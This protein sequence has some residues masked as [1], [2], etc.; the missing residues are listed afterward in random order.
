MFP[1]NGRER[2]LRCFQRLSWRQK[3]TEN[4]EEPKYGDPAASFARVFALDPQAV[5]ARHNLA[6][7]LEKLGR[8]DEAVTQLKRALA[9]KPEYGTG[10]LALGQLY[11][12]MGRTNDADQCYNT[13]LTNR[14]NQADD[15]AALARFCFSRRQFGL[16]V[17]NFAAAVELSPSDPGLRLEAGRALVALGRHD[18]AARQYLRAVELAPDQAQPHMQLGVEQGRLGQPALAEQEF[19]QALRLD[20]NF[21]EARVDLGIALYE[22]EKLDDALK[23]FEDVLQHNPTNATAQ[24]YARLLRNRTTLPAAR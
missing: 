21:I 13:A 20:P 14:V 1:S 10:W 5:W 9:L 2:T 8:R 15:L 18:E 22:Q 12:E 11:E 24:R 6:L 4:S 17:T 7:C 23:Q 19:R 3:S 16:A